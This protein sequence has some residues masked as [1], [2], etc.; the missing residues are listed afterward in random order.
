MQIE[1][2]KLDGNAIGGLLQE[3]LGADVTA[4]PSTC[5]SCRAREE[6]ARLDVYRG[7]GVV[8]RCRHCGAVMIRVVQGRGRTWLDFGGTSTLE[9]A[10]A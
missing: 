6:I 9:L 8:V 3:L 4:A 2:V 7:A 5:A 10:G 1:D